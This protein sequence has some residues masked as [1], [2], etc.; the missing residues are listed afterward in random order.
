[1][2]QMI[3]Y[4]SPIISQ[5]II[6]DIIKDKLQISNL[7]NAFLQLSEFYFTENCQITMFSFFCIFELCKKKL[8]ILASL[9]LFRK[10]K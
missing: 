3:K 8:K 6:E 7:H 5:Y 4:V 10:G 9:I 2:Y 1:M